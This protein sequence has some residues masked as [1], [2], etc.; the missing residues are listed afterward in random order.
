MRNLIY[1][2]LLLIVAWNNP[3]QAQWANPSNPTGL[4]RHLLH[5]A[6]VSVVAG[7]NGRGAMISDKSPRR[8]LLRDF[9]H[10]GQALHFKQAVVIVQVRRRLRHGAEEMSGM[11][12]LPV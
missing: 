11:Q 9:R 1:L 7:E 10:P 3:A 4:P 8:R 5:P 6:A 2:P 12:G